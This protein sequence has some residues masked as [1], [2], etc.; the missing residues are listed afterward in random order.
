MIESSEVKKEFNRIEDENYAFRAY[1]KNHADID[2][3]DQQF[4]KLHKELFINYDCSKCRNCCKEYSASFEEHELATVAD[5][6][7]IS[8][9]EF[10]NNYIEEEL[11]EYQLKKRPCCFL[12]EDGSCEIE[13]CKPESCQGYPFTDRP[14]RMF[15][16]LGIIESASVCPVVFEMFE[17]LKKEYRFKRRRV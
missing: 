6:L 2:E 1:L 7:K 10:R 17:R 16:L 9:K 14:E 15:S 5:F 3:L 13:V 11:G 4:L 12:K 8:E